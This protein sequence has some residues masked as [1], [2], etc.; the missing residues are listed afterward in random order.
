MPQATDT[1]YRMVSPE[2]Y[3]IDGVN[4]D[5]IDDILGGSSTKLEGFAKG[6]N[7]EKYT[8]GQRRIDEADA[9]GASKDESL[10][11]DINDPYE[12]VDGSD[13]TDD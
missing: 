8:I 7:K 4:V 11:A 1:E 9:R 2:D 3:D 6:T 5:E 12:G 13:F 10:R